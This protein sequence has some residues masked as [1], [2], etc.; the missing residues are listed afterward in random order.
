[1]L[2]DNIKNTQHGFPV[3]TTLVDRD[4][5]I[6]EVGDMN[7]KGGLHSCRHI[8]VVSEFER[9]RQCFQLISWKSHR[10]S[11]ERET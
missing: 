9:L 7:P 3:K 5:I 10:N 2:Y 11:S 6:N 1:M 4:D 8:F